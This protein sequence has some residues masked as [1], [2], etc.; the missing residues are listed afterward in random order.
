M[1]WFAA[2]NSCRELGGKLVE[3]D[4]EEEE[5]ALV[6]EINRRGY[7]EANIN[8]WMGFTDLDVEGDWLLESNGLKPDYTNWAEDQPDDLWKPADCARLRTGRFKAWQWSKGWYDF[9]WSGWSDIPCEKKFVQNN[10]YP[11]VFLQALC[12]LYPLT[13][14]STEATTVTEATTTVETAT[15]SGRVNGQSAVTVGGKS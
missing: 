2:N 13:S 9:S 3:I 1:T 4:S 15:Q 11:E 7:T 8:F 6:T 14:S 12:E 5:R 10:G